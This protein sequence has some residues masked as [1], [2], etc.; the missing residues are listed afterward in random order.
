MSRARAR[1]AALSLTSAA[2]NRISTLLHT[3]PQPTLGV[4]V[5]VKTRGCNGLSYTMNYVRPADSDKVRK[6]EVIEAG[7]GV[8]V[9][10]DPKALF[11][12]VGSEMDYKDDD[13]S[14]EF[15]F[16]NPNEKGKCG[17]GESFNV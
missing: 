8:K 11:Y 2:I 15:T 13:L 14:Q 1:K 9:F 17:C 6:D 16:R 3:Q 4:R 7:E 12:I 5:G 10:V